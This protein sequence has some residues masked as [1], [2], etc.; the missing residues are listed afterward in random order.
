MGHPAGGENART[1]KIELTTGIILAV[2]SLISTTFLSNLQSKGLG[3]VLIWVYIIPLIVSI[4]AGAF[5]I[6]L[7]K[8]DSLSK[9]LHKGFLLGII[10]SAVYYVLIIGNAFLWV[11][12]PINY[13]SV[14]LF[15]GGVIM[16]IPVVIGSMLGSFIGFFVTKMFH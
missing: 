15:I 13:E 11:R 5:V 10:G 9:S 2:I 6:H 14:F 8:I 16:A 12:I 7:K 3:D 4:A 1:F